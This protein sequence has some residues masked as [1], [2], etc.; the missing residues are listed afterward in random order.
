MFRE[1]SEGK[2]IS[3]IGLHPRGLPPKSQTQLAS[4][5][6]LRLLIRHAERL[7]EELL[8]LNERGMKPGKEVNKV[9]LR[10]ETR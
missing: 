5:A 9:H 1:A 7:G 2:L 8:L 4:I 6:M 3:D 10:S